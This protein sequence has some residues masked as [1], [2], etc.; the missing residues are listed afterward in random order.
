MLE[1]TAS[2]ISSVLTL[3][4]VVITVIATQKR[5][6]NEIEQKLEVHYAV[7]DEKIDNLTKETEKHNSVIERTYKLEQESAVQ[8]EK[9]TVANKRIGDLEEIVKNEKK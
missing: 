4:G 2:I 7:I 8:A 9:I 1:F 3:V 5:H 6:S